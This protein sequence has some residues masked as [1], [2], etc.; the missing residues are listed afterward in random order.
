MLSSPVPTPTSHSHALL[1][2]LFHTHPTLGLPSQTAST[3]STFQAPGFPHFSL[4]WQKNSPGEECEQVVSMLR[5]RVAMATA[6]RLWLHSLVM[7][8]SDAGPTPA[9][10]GVTGARGSKLKTCKVECMDRTVRGWDLKKAWWPVIAYAWSLC[11]PHS[12]DLG[13]IEWTLQTALAGPIAEEVAT[14]LLQ[15]RQLCATWAGK[16]QGHRYGVNFRQPGA[17]S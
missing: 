1:T 3:S 14:G 10:P 7:S 8:S 13:Y 12:S 16:E 2:K 5:Y 4:K 15:G 11:H 17:T 6:F 9:P